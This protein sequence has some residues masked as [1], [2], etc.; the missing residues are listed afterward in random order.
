VAVVLPLAMALLLV[1]VQ[2][3]VYFHSQAVATTAAHKA[4]D[5]A[6]LVDGTELEG[7]HDAQE[8][9]AQNADGLQDRDVVVRRAGDV[10]TA[11]VSGRVVSVLF[12]VPLHLTV[13]VS[14]PIEQA[15]P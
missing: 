7:T 2:A 6:R 13:V 5:A 14:A 3:A 10:A 11:T 9:L 1:L 4:V 8:F 15:A 12:G